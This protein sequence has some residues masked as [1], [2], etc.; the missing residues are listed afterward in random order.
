MN[1]QPGGKP[2]RRPSDLRLALLIV[3]LAAI[4]FAIVSWAT[5]PAD[6]AT[7]RPLFAPGL[8]RGDR[9]PQVRAAQFLLAGEKP[10][11]Y[12]DIHP[13]R[14]RRIT[15]QYGK[16]TAKAVLR[17]RWLLGEPVTYRAYCQCRPG[18]RAVFDRDLYL[19]LTGRKARPPAWIGFRS[20]RIALADRVQPS[21]P[22]SSCAE[23]IVRWA[24]GEVGV[25]EVGDNGGARVHFYQSS[26]GLYDQAWCDSF[27]MKDFQLAGVWPYPRYA[28]VYLTVEVA[29]EHTLLRSMPAAGAAVAYVCDQGRIRICA[30][31]IGIVER[32]TR[33]GFWTIEGN[34]HDQ[35]ARH[36][37][38]FGD[39][40]VFIY[41][42]CLAAAQPAARRL[43]KQTRS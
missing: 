5:A 22:T 41:P 8:R 36:F 30:G 27:V 2:G 4:V 10:N 42:P 14:G 37:R 12:P 20:R 25:H 32:V 7:K 33:D 38:R 40:T 21:R 17:A 1:A 28:G 13:F 34:S 3:V 24:E 19:I 39:A 35:V 16:F 43:S 26:T 31:H 23:T 9:G 29:R 6:A 15:G 11:H 18:K